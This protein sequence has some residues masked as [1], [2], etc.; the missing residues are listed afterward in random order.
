[1]GGLRH[2]L[3]RAVWDMGYIPHPAFPTDLK[4]ALIIEKSIS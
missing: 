2:W 4:L 1:M 3:R